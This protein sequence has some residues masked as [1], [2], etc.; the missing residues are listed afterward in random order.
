MEW[1]FGNQS[2]LICKI[3]HV[4][5]ILISLPKNYRRITFHYQT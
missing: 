2:H 3:Y 1:G 5:R 4:R